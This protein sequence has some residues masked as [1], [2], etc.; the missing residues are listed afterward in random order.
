MEK[1][2][3]SDENLAADAYNSYIKM[4]NLENPLNFLIE[5]N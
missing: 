5:D 4:N 1:K 3:L 2:N